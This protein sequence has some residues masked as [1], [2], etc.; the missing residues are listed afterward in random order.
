VLY[1]V[2]NL[3]NKVLVLALFVLF[4]LGWFFVVGLVLFAGCFSTRLFALFCV[5]LRWFAFVRV[6]LRL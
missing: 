3:F 6:S 4:V 5:F 2:V 1:F